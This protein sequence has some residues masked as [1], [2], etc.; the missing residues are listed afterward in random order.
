MRFARPEREDVDQHLAGV[1][2]REKRT[3]GEKGG[4]G[5]KG[6]GGGGRE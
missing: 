3:V 2:K 4:R 1:M 5:E 6:G